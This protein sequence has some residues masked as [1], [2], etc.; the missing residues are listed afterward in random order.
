MLRW[1][2]GWPKTGPCRLNASLP[3]RQGS[4]PSDAWPLATSK[5]TDAC[6]CV[7]IRAVDPAVANGCA[8]PHV[9]LPA[10]CRRRADPLQAVGECHV[11]A[12]GD[13]EVAELVADRTLEP[14]RTTRP[15]A[16]SQ[17]LVPSQWVHDVEQQRVRRV[18]GPAAVDVRRA[19]GLGRADLGLRG[20]VAVASPHRPLL[21]LSAA[22]GG[23]GRRRD[24]S[25]SA[26]LAGHARADAP[27][28]ARD[29]AVPCRSPCRTAPR[30]ARA[31]SSTFRPSAGS[32]R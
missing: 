28:M 8:P 9:E 31:R 12:P 16:F 20:G 30:S 17:P 13:G 1:N 15:A 2:A 24:P 3:A 22:A 26:D 29:R 23:V 21:L 27:A 5:G 7:A 14:G 6:S 25:L 4:R 10:V 11:I 19:D 32:R 18:A